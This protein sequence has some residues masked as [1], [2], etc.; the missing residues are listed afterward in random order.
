MPKTHLIVGCGYVGLRVATR[1]KMRGDRVLAITRSATKA[2]SLAGLGVEPVVWDWLGCEPLQTERLPRFD[3]ILIAVSHAPAEGVPV[4]QT[5]TLGLARLVPSV[6]AVSLESRWIYLSTTGVFAPVSD[7]SWVDERSPVAPSRPGSIA[8]WAGERWIE[9]QISSAHRVVLR[10][11]GIYGPERVPRSESIRDGVP[12][13][14]DPDSYVN[15][16]HADD[17]ASAIERVADASTPSPLYCISDG[18]SPTRREYYQTISDWMHWPAPVFDASAERS[19]RSEGN[20]RV[21]PEKIIR[22]MSLRFAYPNYR[23]GLR[24]LLSE[25][26]S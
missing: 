20:K 18:C 8:A 16:I 15:L 21:C 26:S 19:S 12:L 24:S 23:E 2:E 5:H 17:L 9:E 10:P 4:E 6:Q 25:L 22:E 3:S 13:R 11:S 14:V 7:G 1:W